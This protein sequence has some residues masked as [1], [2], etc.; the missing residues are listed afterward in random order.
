MILLFG[1]LI[2]VLIALMVFIELN[3]HLFFLTLLSVAV[4][5]ALMWF[6][7]F[8]ILSGYDLCCVLCFALYDETY[9]C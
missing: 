6:V 7:L 8:S 4:F 2:V 3:I 1:L 9:R 5:A